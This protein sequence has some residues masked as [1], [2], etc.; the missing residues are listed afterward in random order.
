[1]YMFDL[2]RGFNRGYNRPSLSRIHIKHAQ[3]CT[4]QCLIPMGDYK[5]YDGR[6]Y[7]SPSGL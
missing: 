2:N 7:K 1:M 4:F 5:K 3:V 6:G